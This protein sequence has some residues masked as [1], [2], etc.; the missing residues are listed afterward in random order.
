MNSLPAHLRELRGPKM[1]PEWIV[2]GVWVSS[3]EPD[4]AKFPALPEADCAG[5]GYRIVIRIIMTE[6]VFC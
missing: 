3:V 1:I 6:G 2:S 5:Q 4:L